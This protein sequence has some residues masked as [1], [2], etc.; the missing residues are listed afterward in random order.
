MNWGDLKPFLALF[1]ECSL[2]GAA[3]SL[4]VEHATIARRIDRIEAA[5]G[6]KLFDRL[7]RGWRPTYEALAP[8]EKAEVADGTVPC[9]PSRNP[10]RG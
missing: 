8:V 4:R 6:L 10:T 5:L 3:W 1:R 9:E 7:A 2:S